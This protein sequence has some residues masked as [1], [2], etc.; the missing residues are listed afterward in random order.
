MLS[1]KFEKVRKISIVL[2]KIYVFCTH[3]LIFFKDTLED[4]EK[5]TIVRHNNN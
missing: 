4:V 2:V 3:K 5:N 1:V